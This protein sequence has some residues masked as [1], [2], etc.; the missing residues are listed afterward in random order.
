M[1]IYVTDAATEATRLSR[2][3]MLVTPVLL[4]DEL[5]ASFSKIDGSILCDPDGVC[6][7]IGVILDGAANENC[8]PLWG[9]LSRAR[10]CSQS[11]SSLRQYPG[12]ATFAIKR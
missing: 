3:G 2:Q 10:K 8:V 5:L 9:S 11:S 6:H 1:I 4:N 12:D 7:A